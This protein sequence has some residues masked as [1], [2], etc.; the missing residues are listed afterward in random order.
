MPPS[1]V[2]LFSPRPHHPSLQVLA[3]LVRMLGVCVPLLFALVPSEDTPS[4]LWVL[5]H[6]LRALPELR[7]SVVFT[8]GSLAW[9]AAV[10]AYLAAYPG[11][12]VQARC[13]WHVAV[14]RGVLQL[15]QSASADTRDPYRRTL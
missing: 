4:C 6:L 2:V 13:A 10:A 5:E 14:R 3:V 7:G 12:L 1:W 15:I 9:K 11:A 8:D